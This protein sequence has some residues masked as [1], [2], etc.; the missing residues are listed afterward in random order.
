MSTAN[1]R[2]REEATVATT[3]ATSLATTVFALFSGAGMRATNVPTGYGKWVIDFDGQ[4]LPVEPGCGAFLSN[5]PNGTAWEYKKDVCATQL[6]K[7]IK[8]FDIQRGGKRP[9]CPS[10]E[11][12]I[13]DSVAMPEG[14]NLFCIACKVEPCDE[15]RSCMVCKVPCTGVVRLVQGEP[16]CFKCNH[17][18]DAAPLPAVVHRGAKFVPPEALLPVVCPLRFPFFLQG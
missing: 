2:A 1:K 10:C 17:P 18:E 13:K 15:R 14:D 16:V 12:P 7:R 9:I 8:V 11:T 6:D 5:N 4:A 3:V